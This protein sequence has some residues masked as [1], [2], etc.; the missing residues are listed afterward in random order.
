MLL[1]FK[2]QNITF[3]ETSTLYIVINNRTHSFYTA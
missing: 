1:E 2:E 3:I